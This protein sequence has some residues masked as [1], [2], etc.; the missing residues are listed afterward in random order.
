MARAVGFPRSGWSYATTL[1]KIYTRLF[2]ETEADDEVEGI[3]DKWC[4][5][6]D[7]M[8]RDA[9]D[10]DVCSS[11]TRARASRS[12]ACPNRRPNRALGGGKEDGQ[13]ECIGETQS[14]SSCALVL[15]HEGV[16]ARPTGG[17]SVG[18][19]EAER[20][21]RERAEGKRSVEEDMM[22]EEKEDA[23]VGEL[24]KHRCLCRRPRCRLHA[25]C[26]T[27]LMNGKLVRRACSLLPATPAKAAPAADEEHRAEHGSG[28]ASG[29]RD[30]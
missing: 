16:A 11:A 7:D 3:L 19:I 24:D 13:G 29:C 25:S 4:L 12:L 1:K 17:D 22:V 6:A 9:S 28:C 10:D 15:G 2:V 21:G 27:A 5:P 30:A 26:D 20:L 8:L 23:G 18:R 14:K